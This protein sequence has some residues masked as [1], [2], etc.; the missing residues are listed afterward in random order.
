MDSP[1]QHAGQVEHGGPA[2]KHESRQAAEGV[3]AMRLIARLP[4]QTALI[5]LHG[6]RAL[7]SPACKEAALLT[8]ACLLC[9]AALQASSLQGGPNMCLYQTAKR[10]AMLNNA[11]NSGS[12][13]AA[14]DILPRM[15]MPDRYPELSHELAHMRCS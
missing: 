9:P 14:N 7:V 4:S 1:V 8:V 3:A 12:C 5:G 10:R 6:R 2:H 13:Q 15:S 11:P